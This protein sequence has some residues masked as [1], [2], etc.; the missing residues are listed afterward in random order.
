MRRVLVTSPAVRVS[1]VHEF[2][3][4]ALEGVGGARDARFA[5]FFH[6]FGTLYLF[7][8]FLRPIVCIDTG[9]AL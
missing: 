3:A 5:V 4:C 6:L 7:A 2:L 9:S 8:A 1:A